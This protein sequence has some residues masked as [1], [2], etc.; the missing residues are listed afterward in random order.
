MTSTLQDVIVLIPALDPD[1]RL[2]AY[3]DVLRTTGFAHM[4]I[5]DDGSHEQKQPIFQRIAEMDG[6]AVLHHP[7]NRGKGVALKTGYQYIS[8]HFPQAHYV[9]TADSDGQH[10]ASDCQKVCQAAFAGQEG[11]YLGSRD[12]TLDFIPPKSRFGNKMTSRVFQLFYGTY[13][14]DTQT[15]LRVFPHSELAFMM[16]VEGERYEYEMNVLIACARRKIPMIPVTIETIYENNNE[17]THFHPIRD[18]YRIYKVIL[19]NFFRFMASS[20]FCVLVDQGLAAFLAEFLLPRLGM[21]DSTG[22]LWVSGF[23]A[24]IVSAVTN[25]FLNKE[26]VFKL[27]GAAGKA[28]LRYGVLCIAVIVLSN[29]GVTL[30]TAIS[31]PRWIAKLLCDTLLY[32]FSYRMQRSWVFREEKA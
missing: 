18:S 8:E 32:F 7:V 19:G 24:R 28:A 11:L 26:F 27:K 25:F 2:I 10:T 16:D 13:L 9:L 22:I 23:L 3:L 1:D 31:I 29:L 17:G 4:V 14:P 6:C 5:V 12:F 20:I 15:G 30:L 21:T